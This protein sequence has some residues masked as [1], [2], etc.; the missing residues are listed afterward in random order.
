MEDLTLRAEELPDAAIASAQSETGLV[1]LAGNVSLTAS[2][3]EGD[4][5][6]SFPHDVEIVP[7]TADQPG[8]AKSFTPAIELVTKVDPAKVAGLEQSSIAMYTRTRP[9]DPWLRLPSAYDAET[10]SVVAHS[11]HLSE[12]TVMGAVAAAATGPARRAGHRRRRG[13]CP[14]GRRH[15]SRSDLQRA[16]RKCAGANPRAV[17]RCK[18]TSHPAEPRRPVRLPHL[19]THDDEQPQPRSH[20]DVG[21]QRVDRLPVGR[22]E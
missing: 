20:G 19:A 17:L 3:V 21:V 14:L 9:G 15:A 5:V 7:A 16:P 11:D 4:G 13:S 12:F 1:S 2:N 18:R 8:Y 22:P 10:H 6:S